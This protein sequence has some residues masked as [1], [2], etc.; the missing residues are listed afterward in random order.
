MIDHVSLHVSNYAKSKEFYK[1]ALAPLGYS[2]A[3]DHQTSGGFGSE[4]KADFWISQKETTQKAHV[5]FAAPSRKQVDAV[6]KAALEAGAKDNG[7]PGVRKDYS[8][9]YYAAFFLDADGNN[10]ETVCRAAS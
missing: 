6:Y 3:M 5:A 8:P 10:I 4:G 9:T 1:K 7:K 2:L